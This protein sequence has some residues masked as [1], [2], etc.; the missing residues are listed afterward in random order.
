MEHRLYEFGYFQIKS[1]IIDQYNYIGLISADIFLA[2][3][4]IIQ[5]RTQVEQHRNKPIKAIS[6]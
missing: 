1:R 3:L 5:D 6:L 2:S 4:H